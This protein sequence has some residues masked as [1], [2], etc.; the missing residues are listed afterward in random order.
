[1]QSLAPPRP[2]GI[3]LLLHTLAPTAIGIIVYVV[4][5]FVVTL[6]H[7]V[8]LS[9]NGTA[10]PASFNDIL[11]MSYANFII[12][13]LIVAANS[14]LLNSGL[15]LLL[16]AIAGSVICALL[17]ALITIIVSWRNTHDDITVPRYGVVVRHPLQRSLILRFLWHVTIGIMLILHTALAIAIARTCFA[18]DAA[19]LAAHTLTQVTRHFLLNMTLW[20]MIFYGYTVLLRFYVFRTRLFGEILY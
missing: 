2:R 20:S 13:P 3:A 1:M 18:N 4:L 19:I 7:L 15:I 9:V 14:D 5:A 6:T 17:N 10:Y 8:L 12:R 11:L 16:W